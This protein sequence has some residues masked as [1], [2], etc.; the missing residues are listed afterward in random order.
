[1]LEGIKIIDSSIAELFSK[2]NETIILGLESVN[3][4]V[5]R[6]LGNTHGVI[7]YSTVV[8]KKVRELVEGI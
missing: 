8:A 5:A 7:G 3:D 2:T 1:L 6:A 4:K